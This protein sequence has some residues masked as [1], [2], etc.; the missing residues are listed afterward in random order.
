[1]DEEEV[2]SELLPLFIFDDILSEQEHQS[3]APKEQRMA[4]SQTW[5]RIGCENFSYSELLAAE[6]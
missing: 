4:D 1:M 2:A 3:L 6:M 5:E